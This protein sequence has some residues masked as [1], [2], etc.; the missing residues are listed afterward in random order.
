[1]IESLAI[2]NGASGP[3]ALLHLLT[4]LRYPRAV[5][6]RPVRV[7]E[8]LL[9]V[10]EALLEAHHHELHGWAITKATRRSSPTVYTILERLTDSGIITARWEDLSQEPGRPRR[11]FYRLTG[12]GATVA[13]E[14]L[15]DRRPAR[16]RPVRRRPAAGWAGA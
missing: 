11:R 7:T 8:P 1:V 12:H 16:T 2:G 5:T 10:L 3:F 6:D 9:D 4:S 15:K 14:M 13:A